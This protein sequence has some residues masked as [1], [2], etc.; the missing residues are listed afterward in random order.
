M[1]II[2]NT[3]AEALRAIHDLQID[4]PRW[5]YL[6]REGSVKDAPYENSDYPHSWTVGTGRTLL[7]DH[8]T[9]EQVMLI[10][11]NPLHPH[12]KGWVDKYKEEPA[13]EGV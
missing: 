12:F 10:H 8:R 11:A 2:F 5:L 6:I 7:T 3:W 13:R 9:G 1:K 4:G